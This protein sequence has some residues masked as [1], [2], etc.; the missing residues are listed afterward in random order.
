[1]NNDNQATEIF[2]TRIENND[3]PFSETLDYIDKHYVFSAS[4]FTNGALDN[5]SD[6]NQGS[7]RVLALASLLKLTTEQTLR[8]FGEHY[9]D[10]L[11]SP[12]GNSHQNI[13]QLQHHGMEAVR[14][15]HFPLRTK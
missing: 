11:A 3:H 12:D 6:Q 14:F 1:M 15:E 9:R 8:C 10:V 5:S 2:L 7:C 4:A 13:R